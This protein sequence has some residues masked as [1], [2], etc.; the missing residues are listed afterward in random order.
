MRGINTATDSRGALEFN[1]PVSVGEFT[2][3]ANKVERNSFRSNRGRKRRSFQERVESAVLATLSAGPGELDLRR[4]SLKWFHLSATGSRRRIRRRYKSRWKRTR[5]PRD[6]RLPK[7]FHLPDKN[8]PSSATLLRLLRLSYSPGPVTADRRPRQE[9]ELIFGAD[10]R[11]Y[12]QSCRPL[13]YAARPSVHPSIRRVVVAAADAAAAAAAVAAV[14]AAR[15]V[16]PCQETNE[17]RSSCPLGAQ[18]KRRPETIAVAVT[19]SWIL[20][21]WPLL[22]SVPICVHV[23]FSYRVWC[24]WRNCASARIV[25]LLKMPGRRTDGET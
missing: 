24:N 8:C 3:R 15:R 20:D 6:A 11:N 19:A 25:R 2:C 17:R 5:S 21:N 14:V 4:R 18:W 13:V 9:F 16:A 1:G 10:V 22:H 23:Q 7:I 12:R